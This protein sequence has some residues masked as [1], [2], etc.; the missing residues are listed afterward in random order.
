M[1]EADAGNYQR[2]AQILS[3]QNAALIR[4]YTAAPAAVQEQIRLETNN[5]ND[6]AGQLNG[7]SYNGA[8]RKAMQSQSY[9]SRNSK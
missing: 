8:S 2:A 7:G 3:T 9:N 1:A 4:A 5:L 6:F